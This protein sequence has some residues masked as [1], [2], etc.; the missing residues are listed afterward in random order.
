MIGTVTAYLV[1]AFIRIIDVKRF[2]DIGINWKKLIGNTI[3]IML[4]VIITSVG[5]VGLGISASVLLMGVFL[6]LNKEE[7]V[8]AVNF[9]LR[10]GQNHV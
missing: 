4:Q 1:L 2:V 5:S 3:I 10:R 7:L 6:I 8:M 9:A